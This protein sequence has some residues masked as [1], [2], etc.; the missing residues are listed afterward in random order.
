MNKCKDCTGFGWGECVTAGANEIAC[1][2]FELRQEKPDAARI[3]KLVEHIRT[4]CEQTYNSEK[5]MQYAEM[6][7]IEQLCDEI[8]REIQDNETD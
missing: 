8:E 1:K 5:P 7:K 6:S 3:A 2:D 4:I